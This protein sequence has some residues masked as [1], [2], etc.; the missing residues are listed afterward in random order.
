MESYQFSKLP[1]VPNDFPAIQ[2]KLN[3]FTEKIK[4]ASSVEE[5][6][7]IIGQCDAL[8]EETG[9]QMTLAY[10]RSSLDCTDQFYAEAIQ[11]ESAGCATLEQAPYTNAL[12]ESLSAGAGE[13]IR[14]RIPSTPGAGGQAAFL[15]AGADGQ[16]ERTGEPVPAEK[17]DGED[18]LPGQGLLGGGDVRPF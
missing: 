15:R 1:Y 18:P 3:G 10:I 17:G 4:S 14:P 5:V 12:L 7:E 8:L 6:L 13:E 2:E 16:G 9:H 11:R